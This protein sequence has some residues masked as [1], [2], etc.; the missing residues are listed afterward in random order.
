MVWY[1]KALEQRR[2][3]AAGGDGGPPSKGAVLDGLLML[4]SEHVELRA[5]R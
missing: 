2:Q 1:T 4:G 5:A 3:T